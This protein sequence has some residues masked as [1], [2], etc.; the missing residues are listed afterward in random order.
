MNHTILRCLLYTSAGHNQT[1]RIGVPQNMEPDGGGDAGGLTGGFHGPDLVALTPRSAIRLCEHQRVSSFACGLDREKLHRLFRERHVSRLA[2]FARPDVQH[3]SGGIEVSSAKP[4]QFAIPSTAKQ[5]RLYHWTKCLAGG[6][7]QTLGLGIGK[8]TDARGVGVLEGRHA[9]PCVI[10]G[11]FAIRIGKIQG[12][13]QHGQDTVC[14][15]AAG[16]LALGVIGVNRLSITVA[17]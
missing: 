7:H 2:G 17:L 8:I 11:Y 15:R 6:V 9:A 12:G 16:A 14:T 4:A 13:L 5:S 3:G 1:A 10:A